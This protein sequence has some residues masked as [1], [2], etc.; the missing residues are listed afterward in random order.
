MMKVMEAHSSNIKALSSTLESK[1]A[2]IARL[3]AD[4]DVWQKKAS[5]L[6]ASGEGAALPSVTSSPPHRR[7]PNFTRALLAAEIGCFRMRLMI[8]CDSN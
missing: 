2:E 3:K 8:P 5:D 4:L 1:Q 7:F 6:E